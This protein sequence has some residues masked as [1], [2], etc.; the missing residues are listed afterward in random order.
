MHAAARWK[1]R[2]FVMRKIVF[3]L[4]K[5]PSVALKKMHAVPRSVKNP[6]AVRQRKKH[7]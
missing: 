1:V 7:V 4:L 3:A 6:L 2:W 5:K